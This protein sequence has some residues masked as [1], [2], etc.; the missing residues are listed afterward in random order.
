MI[1]KT[2]I[3]SVLAKHGYVFVVFEIYDG[4]EQEWSSSASY[5]YISQQLESTPSR[6]M[7]G[8]SY[9]IN[10]QLWSLSQIALVV[11]LDF[12]SSQ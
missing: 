6:V 11:L 4:K 8:G 1:L 12:D 7:N 10:S 5:Q 9:M 2:A 3:H